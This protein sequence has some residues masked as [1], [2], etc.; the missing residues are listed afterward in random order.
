MSNDFKFY[1]LIL[2]TEPTDFFDTVCIKCDF[3]HS[4]NF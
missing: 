1:D 3:T 2:V 4:V